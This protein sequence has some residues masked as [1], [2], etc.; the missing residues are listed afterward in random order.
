VSIAIGAFEDTYCLLDF[1]EMVAHPTLLVLQKI[2]VDEE[3]IL[4][5]FP[6]IV[7]AAPD[8]LNATPFVMAHNIPFHELQARVALH[9]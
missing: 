9:I 4:P 7:E 1:D 3:A 5:S 2:T 8:E 6:N